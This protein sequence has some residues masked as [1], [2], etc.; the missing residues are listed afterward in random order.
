MNGIDYRGFAWLAL[1][2]LWYLV[3]LAFAL[4]I[5]LLEAN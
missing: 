3:A 4:R 1:L 2:I 5:F